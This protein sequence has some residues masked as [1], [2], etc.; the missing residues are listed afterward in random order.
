MEEKQSTCLNPNVL[1][2]DGALLFQNQLEFIK[3]L[4]AHIKITYYNLKENELNKFAAVSAKVNKIVVVRKTKS[5]SS[6][7]ISSVLVC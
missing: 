7:Q 5:D 3:T 4:L 6:P 2:S 1:L